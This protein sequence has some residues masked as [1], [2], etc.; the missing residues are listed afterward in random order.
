MFGQKQ[1]SGKCGD[2]LLEVDEVGE[3]LMQTTLISA[4]SL[5]AYERLL[6]LCEVEHDNPICKVMKA[7][8]SLLANDISDSLIHLK[9]FNDLLDVC[10]EIDQWNG[11]GKEMAKREVKSAITTFVWLL[12]TQLDCKK[13][14]ANGAVYEARMA[15]LNAWRETSRV[16]LMATQRTCSMLVQYN[17]ALPVAVALGMLNDGRDCM[18]DARSLQVQEVDEGMIV[19]DNSE[20]KGLLASLVDAIWN[21]K[22]QAVEA[23]R[24][25]DEYSD[26]VKEFLSLIETVITKLERYSDRIGKSV[27]ISEMIR[28]YAEFMRMVELNNIVEPVPPKEPRRW[29]TFRLSLIFDD[30]LKKVC[31]AIISVVAFCFCCNC[32]EGFATRLLIVSSVIVVP[33]VAYR[34]VKVAYAVKKDIEDFRKWEKRY[35]EAMQKYQTVTLREFE[36][37]KAR[38]EETYVQRLNVAHMFDL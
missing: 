9:A 2:L 7:Q 14:R 19:E 35:D 11:A 21:S 22:K 24:R 29:I 37:Q 36:S 1:Q 15:E 33:I 16:A 28:D 26:A 18:E 12:R 31:I 34:S 32:F 25:I 20:K 5:P 6:N 23:E 27:K 17:V 10:V 3:D 13:K 38:A 30:T 4:N 8:L